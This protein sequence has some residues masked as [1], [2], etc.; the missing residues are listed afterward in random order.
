M[1]VMLKNQLNK[2]EKMSLS[3]DEEAWERLL[4]AEIDAL[5]ENNFRLPWQERLPE[6]IA[7]SLRPF[8]RQLEANY[9][10]M[11]N[12]LEMTQD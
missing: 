1:L 5:E 9:S 3:P 10:S 6:I 2:L 4:K 7:K 12:V 11:T 8:R